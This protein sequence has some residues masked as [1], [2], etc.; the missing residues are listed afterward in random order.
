MNVV[1]TNNTEKVLHFER[2]IMTFKTDF[3]ILK[4]ELIW[5]KHDRYQISGPSTICLINIQWNWPS[6]PTV[7]YCDIFSFLISPIYFTVAWLIDGPNEPCEVVP[8]ISSKM[9]TFSSFYSDNIED[10]QTIRTV[11][12]FPHWHD[13]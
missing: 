3:I 8:R 13:F 6:F 1:R 5:L 10:L 7:I 2:W 9:L 11:K 4:L 12:V